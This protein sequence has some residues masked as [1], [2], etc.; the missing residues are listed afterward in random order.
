M[1]QVIILQYPHGTF[2]YDHGE[3]SKIDKYNIYYQI[4]TEGG[5]SGAPVQLL[6][7]GEAITI[8]T[9]LTIDNTCNNIR[10]RIG[11]SFIAIC[12]DFIFQLNSNTRYNKN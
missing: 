7:N 12:E 9:T 3:I 8:H 5:S 4:G 11:I 2:S 1:F 10:F 6:S